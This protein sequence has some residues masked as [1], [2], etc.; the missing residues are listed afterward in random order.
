[1]FGFWDWVGGRY[2]VWGAVGLPLM[3]AIGPERFAEFLAGAH[4][5]D[6]HFVD[7]AAAREPAGAARRSS[8][9]WHRN[10]M[11]YAS[12]A[13]LP[14]DQR[15]ARLPAYLQQLDM[16]SNGKSRRRSTARPCRA[17]P[18]RSSGASPAPTASTPSTS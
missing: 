8:A 3:L 5:M 18:A 9:I 11:G 13:V 17:P 2:S 7:G 12:R 15:L 16:E 6:R 1:M 4:A 10:V 14:Y